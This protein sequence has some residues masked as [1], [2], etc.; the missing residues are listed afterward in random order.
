MQARSEGKKKRY[1]PPTV[2]KHTLEQA[3]QFVVDRT[4]CT[5]QEAVDLLESLRRKQQQ[6]EKE[7]SQT[8]ADDNK[9]ER[10]A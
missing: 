1:S 4:N 10:S 3:K 6:S 2:T 5:D 9:R 7:S 8:S